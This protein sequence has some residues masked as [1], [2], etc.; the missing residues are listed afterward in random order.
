VTPAMGVFSRE[1]F[2]PVLAIASFADIEEALDLANNSPYALSSAIFTKNLDTAHRYIDRIEAGL[3]EVNMHTGFK[4][5][6]LE[7]FLNRK[8]VYVRK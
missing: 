2:D 4:D 6:G 1:I 8:A 3:A 7:F 5:P